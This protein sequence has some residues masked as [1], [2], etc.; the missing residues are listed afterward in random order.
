MPAQAGIQAGEQRAAA[1]PS[2]AKFQAV[3]SSLGAMLRVGAPRRSGEGAAV[4]ADRLAVDVRAVGRG[5]QGDDTGDDLRPARLVERH[6]ALQQLPVKPL[7]EMLAAAHGGL[8]R[9]RTDGVGAQSLL[10]VLDGE[11]AGQGE[12]ARLAGAVDRAVGHAGEC[13]RRRGVDDVA[14]ARQQVRQRR[15]AE[16]K[17]PREVDAEHLVPALQAE[18]VGVVEAEDAGDVH[19]H[20]ELSEAVDAGAH[21]RV[22]LRGLADVAGLHLDRGAQRAAL[23]G[24]LA[25]RVRLQVDEKETGALGGQPLGGG[26]PD[27]G[28]AAGDQCNLVLEAFQFDLLVMSCRERR[29]GGALLSYPTSVW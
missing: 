13:R 1:R 11:C 20:V 14:A 29:R 12:H 23:F 17:G 15:P 7:G 28:R 10:G 21:G 22:H 24:T 16:Q 27:A 26:P 2:R 3:G 6:G 8:D 18:L 4:D 5:E 25:Q 19:Q 9:A